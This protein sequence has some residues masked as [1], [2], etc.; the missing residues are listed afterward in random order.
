MRWVMILA[1]ARYLVAGELIAALILRVSGVPLEPM[2]GD[3][4]SR[5]EIIE[6]QPEWLVL[7]RFFVRCFP[8]VSFPV[9]NPLGDALAEVLGVGI[10][11]NETRS[12]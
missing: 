12:F 11:V 3:G 2:P 6:F 10:E 9:V 5:D 7:D 4:M 1:E 8:T